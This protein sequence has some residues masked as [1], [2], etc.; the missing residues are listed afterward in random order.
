MV[1]WL[2]HKHIVYLSSSS[3]HS[4]SP[5]ICT[6][7]P[8]GSA[9]QI[10]RREL[11]VHSDEVWIDDCIVPWFIRSCTVNVIGRYIVSH[12]LWRCD[13]LR[14]SV[15]TAI[16]FN[17]VCIVSAKEKPMKMSFKYPIRVGGSAK[18]HT[19]H[20]AVDASTKCTANDFGLWNPCVCVFDKK[21]IYGENEAYPL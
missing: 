3:T 1:N 2:F 19:K 11:T 14:I 4:L 15:G 18:I 5:Y 21:L 7:R 9:S 10:R 13:R 17:F 12:I 20:N 8:S 6:I 16:V